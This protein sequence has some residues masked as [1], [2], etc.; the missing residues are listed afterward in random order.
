M[1]TF[2]QYRREYTLA[3]LDESQLTDEPFTL[4]KTWLDDAIKADIP[5]PNAMTVATV[6]S[7]GRP[8][9]RIV[10]LKDLTEEG[11]VFYTNLG[12]RKAQELKHN[13]NIALHFPW[14]FIERQVRVCGVAEP[15]SRAK[16]AQYFFSRPKDSQLAAIASKQSQPISTKQAL[17]TQFAQ[18]KEKFAQGE[19]PLPDFW[20]GY[21]VRPEQI[22]FWQGGEH[23]LHDRFEYTKLEDASWTIQR[24]NP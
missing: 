15:L 24:L 23:R 20:G 5:D 3:T 21:L 10:L 14:H 1:S 6:D 8:S 12:S 9:Q 13:P 22:E 16:V 7:S 19:V 11:F 4:F 18:L 2:N 17:L